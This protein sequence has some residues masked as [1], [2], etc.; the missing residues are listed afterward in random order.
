MLDLGFGAAYVVQGGDIGSKV[1]RVL[2]AGHEACKVVH[3]NFGIMPEPAG[4]DS[5]LFTP[6]E[7]IGRQRAE[8]FISTGS[9]YALLHATRPSTISFGLASNPF[10]SLPGLER[11]SKNG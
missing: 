2:A 5:S 9:A 3:L 10:P 8:D 4:A 6:A 7:K 11:S 1:A